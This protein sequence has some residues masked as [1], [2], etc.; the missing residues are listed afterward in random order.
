MKQK[1]LLVRFTVISG[2]VIALACAS[3]PDYSSAKSNIKDSQTQASTKPAVPK[4]ISAAISPPSLKSKKMAALTFDDGPDKKY[5]DKVL[6]I[7]RDYK[8]K[9]TFFI[10]GEKTRQYP[11]VVKRINQDGHALGNHS[12]NHPNLSKL[13]QQEL[14]QEI[15]KT[16]EAI[17]E[18]TGFAP[19]LL[20]PPYGAAS[21]QVKKEIT[22][23]GHTLALWS[24]DTL[25]WAGTSSADIIKAV[26]SGPK[27]NAVVLMHTGGGRNGNLDNTI[28]ALP[29]I[30]E[31]YQSQGYDLVT[32]P[33]LKGLDDKIKQ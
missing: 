4:N 24:I 16:D 20:R 30:I 10:L 7:L 28:R 2:L 6:D 15:K 18:V 13:S 11:G 27:E 8:V 5:T 32:L 21:D 26:K 22:A 33:E 23:S 25:D 12:W 31:Y 29:K 14:R 1:K 9:G 17:R 3:T 19:M